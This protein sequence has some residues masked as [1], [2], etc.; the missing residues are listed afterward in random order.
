MNFSQNPVVSKTP[1]NIITKPIGPICNIDCAY[2]FYLE[3]TKLY[4]RTKSF[5]MNEDVL[6]QYVRQYIEGQPEDTPEISFGWQGGEPTLMGIPF[7][8]SALQFQKKYKRPGMNIQNSVQSNGTLLNDDWGTFFHDNHFFLGIS[9]DGPEAIHDH[10][11]NDKKGR[12]TFQ[13]VMRGIEICQKYNVEFNTLTVVQ[14]HNGEHPVQIY[15][16]LKKIGSTF[17]QFIPIVVHSDNRVMDK[18]LEGMIFASEENALESNISVSEYSIG[19]EQWGHFLNKVFDRWLGKEDVGKIFVRDFDLM[20]SMVMGLPSSLCVN[21]K[22]CG[23][24]VAIEHNGDLYSC[25]H[26]VHNDYKLGNINQQSL[27]EMMDSEQQIKFGN[28]KCETLPQYCLDCD[29]LKYCWGACPKDRI[30]KTPQGESGLN[31]LC[32]G[33][34]AFYSHTEPYFQKMAECLRMGY[35]AEDWNNLGALKEQARH[36]KPLQKPDKKM[37]RNGPCLC[38]SGKKYKKCCG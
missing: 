28:D 27:T 11:R 15:D 29:F 5:K 6:E 3:K 2:C 37:G 17:F 25:D 18:Q 26:Y 7:F 16:F 20:L 21:A 19:P 10:F 24:E 32:E 8:K 35:F 14:S 23:R 30:K 13:Q 9:I 22:T 34:K 38:G 31:Y 4:P 33:Y 36:S 12:G 1:F